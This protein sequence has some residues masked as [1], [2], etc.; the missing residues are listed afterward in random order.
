MACGAGFSGADGNR[1]GV[2][3]GSGGNVYAGADGN[4]YKKTDN[5]WEKYT[6]T[7]GSGTWQP[8]NQQTAQQGLQNRTGGGSQNL[9]GQTQGR[10]SQIPSERSP[11]LA[12]QSERF[13][14]FR[15]QF[16]G[17]G[18]LENDHAARL[19]GERSFQQF[20]AMR[21]GGFAGRGGGGHFRR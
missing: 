5:G 18:Q 4:V 19:G 20:G 14:S 3:Q 11:N 9:S 1:G 13:G 7:G 17:H 6:G 15:E 21:G 8:V 12:G 2:V 10:A 16:Q